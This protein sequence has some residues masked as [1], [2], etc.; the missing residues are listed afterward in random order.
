M[1]AA[2]TRYECYRMFKGVGVTENSDGCGWM[3]VVDSGMPCMFVVVAQEKCQA[4]KQRGHAWQST[5]FIHCANID[6]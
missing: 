4:R 2:C 1:N 6:Y 5:S 3:G